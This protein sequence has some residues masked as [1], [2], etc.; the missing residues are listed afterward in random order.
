MQHMAT[1]AMLDSSQLKASWQQLTFADGVQDCML[2]AGTAVANGTCRGI[3]NAIGMSTE[4]G[5][6]QQQ[7]TDAAAE[8]EDT[9]LKKKLDIFGERL[10]Q[11]IISFLTPTQ[12][13]TSFGLHVQSLRP[14]KLVSTPSAQHDLR[15]TRGASSEPHMIPSAAAAKSLS[16]LPASSP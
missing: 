8:E 7:I 11:V 9:P 1:Q 5:A 10:A 2:F 6:I 13:H 4:V 12:S 16:M 14:S 3:V 15:L